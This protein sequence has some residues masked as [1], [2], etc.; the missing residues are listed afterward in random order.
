MALRFFLFLNFNIHCHLPHNTFV[1]IPLCL[2]GSTKC[3]VHDKIG[4][5]RWEDRKASSLVKIRSIRT[6]DTKAVSRAKNSP[7][8]TDDTKP[9]S[10]VKIGVVDEG[11]EGKIS[12][13]DSIHSD[14]RYQGELSSGESIHSDGRYEGSLASKEFIPIHPSGRAIRRRGF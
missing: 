9:R 1:H 14:G 11:I 6:D 8:R 13:E 2:D 12:G 10:L 4:S 7:I 3:S 5:L